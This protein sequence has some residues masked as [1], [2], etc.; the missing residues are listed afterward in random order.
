MKQ[1]TIIITETKKNNTHQNKLLKKIITINEYF[2]NFP[3]FLYLF[4][5]FN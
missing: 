2:Q 3:Q 1:K 4:Q 5:S